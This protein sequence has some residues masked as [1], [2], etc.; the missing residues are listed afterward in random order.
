MGPSPT[1]QL[2]PIFSRPISF[3]IPLLAVVVASGLFD[4]LRNVL[5]RDIIALL[6]LLLIFTLAEIGQRG[7]WWV[8]PVAAFAA[9]NFLFTQPYYTF[10][11]SHPE[12]WLMLAVFLLV[13][14]MSSLQVRRLRE[15][16]REAEDRQKDLQLLNRLS[17]QLVSAATIQNMTDALNAALAMA[18]VN[19]VTLFVSEQGEERRS[20]VPFGDEPSTGESDVAEWVARENKAVGLPT[21]SVAAQSGEPWP[22]AGSGPS[23]VHVS[24]SFLPLHSTSGLRG[25]LLAARAGAAP[26]QP[27][28]ARVLVSA[29]N[30]ATTFLD[31]RELQRQANVLASVE[32]ADR[33]KSSLISSVSHDIKTPLAAAKAHVTGLLVGDVVAD[34]QAERE[35]LRA[36]AEALDRLGTMID[37][38]LDISRLESDAWQPHVECY[39]LGEVLSAV[40]ADLRPDQKARVHVRIEADLP[41]VRIDFRQFQSAVRNLVANALA[42]SAGE[43]W[44]DANTSESVTVLEVRDSG[45]GVSDAEKAHVFDKFFRGSASGSVP[46]GSGLGLAIVREIVRVHGGTVRV[47]DAA[48]HGARFIITLPAE[49]PAK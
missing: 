9:M 3:I 16:T 42:Y 25:V 29:A 21:A 5:G 35:D 7:T 33:L 23:G 12:D 38:L 19:R 31:R 2:V 22:V 13:G 40:L 15:R 30:L 4:L 1:K 11:V 45:P 37:G 26:I 39:E 18:G 17:R 14:V 6:Y 8:A 34:P 47:E 44:I 36:T 49:G 24:G 46:G 10:W 32:E 28:E 48:P 20:L 27:S 41:E 43:V